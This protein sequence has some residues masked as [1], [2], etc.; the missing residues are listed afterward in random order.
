MMQEKRQF[1]RHP[2]SYPLR[3][4]VTSEEK[5]E[6]SH[7]LNISKG[8]L[9]F[10]SRY[11]AKL[12]AIITL[13]LPFQNKAFKVKAKVV[14]IEKDK[15][16]PRLYNIGVSFDQHSDAFK[17]KL[18]EQIYLI[19]EYRSLRSIELGHEMGMREASEEWIKR[20]SVAFDKLFW[21]SD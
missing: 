2:I 7:T 5:H 6:D 18:I 11:K 12:G 13:K 14:H 15:D 9:L 1:L 16:N 20:Y 8:G 17:V 4:E 10:L 3:F 21:K 19:D